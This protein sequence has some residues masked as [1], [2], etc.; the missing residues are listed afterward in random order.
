VVKRVAFLT[1]Y[2]QLAASSRLRAFQYKS[3]IDSS[4]CEINIQSLLDDEY[5]SDRFNNRSIRLRHIFHLFLKRILFLF[6]INRYD[7]VVVHIDLFPYMPPVIEWL[8][9]HSRPKIYFDY[10]DAVFHH[11]EYS[12]NFLVRFF[13]SGKIKFLMKNADGVICC[14]KYIQSYAINSGAKR[15]VI[16][17]TSIDL[18]MYSPRN[19]YDV[20]DDGFVVG[21]IGSPSTSKYIEI[22]SEA[23]SRLGQ[24]CP[25]LLYLVGADNSNEISIENVKIVSVPWSI[26]N[27]Q[28]AL[29]IINVGI[30]PLYDG[31]WDRGKCAFK[32]IHYMA[33]SLPVVASGVGMNADLVTD[34]NGFISDTSSEWFDVLYKLYCDRDLRKKL[35][36][37]G[38]K[39]VE[40]EYTINVNVPKFIE[41]VGL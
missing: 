5:L 17:P 19:S 3:N 20:S 36:V 29:R 41:F 13:L 38:R 4:V 21:W 23:L 12:G 25:V 30:M 2:G 33:S 7:I 15:T 22:V 6:G 14:N 40:S 31:P 34:E 9:F 37:N 35:G 26:D 10:D 18:R 27:E 11:Y 32:L 8:L 28:A 24:V 39:L 1:K 16:L